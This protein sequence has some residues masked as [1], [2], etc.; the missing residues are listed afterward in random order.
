MRHLASFTDLNL[1]VARI[2][3]SPGEERLIAEI[4]TLRREVERLEGVIV[5]LTGGPN[6]IIGRSSHETI[7]R[8]SAMF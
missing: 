5:A 3:A 7:C 8:D 2:G 6:R 1:D 4:D